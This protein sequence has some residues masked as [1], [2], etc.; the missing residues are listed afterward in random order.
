VGLDKVPVVSHLRAGG[1]HQTLLFC[2]LA[3]SNNAPAA[4]R[5]NGDRLFNKDVLAGFYGCLKL[6]RPKK[7]GRRHKDNLRIGLHKGLIAGRAAEASL[8]RNV[9]LFPCIKRPLLKI[10]GGSND[11]NGQAKNLAR[12]ERIGSGSATPAA[13]AEQSHFEG[14]ALPLGGCSDY[15]WSA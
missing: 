3:G 1:N 13:A 5:V 15:S 2:L 8:R 11:L 9:Q 12:F 7:R 10:V 14:S 6:Q 4:G